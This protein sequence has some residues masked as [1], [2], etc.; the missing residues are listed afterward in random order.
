MK[1]T[2]IGTGYVGLVAGTCLSELGNDVVCLDVDQEKI[3]KLNNGIV[4]IYEPGLEELFKRNKKEGRLTFTTDKEKAIKTSHVIFIAVGTPMGENHEADLRFVKVVAKDIGTYM[5]EYKVVVDKST[6]PVGTADMVKKI[7]KE[8]Q[9]KDIEVDVVSNPEF[10]REGSAL[11]DFQNPDRVVIGSDSEKAK[12]IMEKIYGAVARIGRPILHTDIKSAELIKYASNA[13]LATRISFMNELANLS[14]KVGADI[15]KVAQGIGLDTRIGPRFLQAGVGYGGSCFPKD[16]QALIQTLKQNNCEASILTAVEEVNQKQKLS[17]IPKI[18][19][20]V[21]DLNG[22]TIAVWGLAF[23]PKTDDIREAPAIFIINELQKL[24]AK[25]KAFDPVAQENVKKLLN[26]VEY[27]QNPYNAID[28]ADALVICTEWDEFRDL[29]KGK[30]KSL[31][32]QP[33]IVDGR[34]IYNPKE[35]KEL[36]FNYIGVGR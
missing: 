18:Q 27:T 21:P 6:V 19:K 4:P 5:Q 8:N 2:V 9:T 29:D 20:L 17:L 28:G 11:K 33:N 10:L 12:Q 36:G 35:M 15:K 31:L 13:M 22:K 26:D 16:V 30:I 23:K 24:G 14:E 32:K 1:I 34:N 7:I 25:V 3:D